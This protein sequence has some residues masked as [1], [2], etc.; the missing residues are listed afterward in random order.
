MQ[1][2]KRGAWGGKAGTMEKRTRREGMKKND[3]ITGGV[4]E[5]GVHTKDNSLG[6]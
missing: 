1:L 4:D 6:K 2:E 3:Q 5:Q